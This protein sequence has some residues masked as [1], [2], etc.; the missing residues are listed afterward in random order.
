[1]GRLAVGRRMTGLVA[2]VLMTVAAAGAVTT[3]RDDDARWVVVRDAS[4]AELARTA[5]PP[6]QEFALRYRNSVYGSLAEERF[7]VKG[8][9]LRLVELGADERAVLEEY[10]AAPGSVRG[11]AGGRAWSVAVERP[12]I[13]LPLHVQSTALGE[14]TL[15]TESG[16]ISLWRLVAGRDDTLVVLSVEGSG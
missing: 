2:A 12:P 3:A 5:L 13:A 8:D 4:G 15:L 6:S 1:M 11:A 7:A 10:Y 16:E 14:R 9:R